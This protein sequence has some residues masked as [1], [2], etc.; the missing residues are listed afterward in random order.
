MYLHLLHCKVSP[1]TLPYPLLKV[2]Y[3]GN[4]SARN[5]PCNRNVLSKSY[6]RSPFV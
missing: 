6:M 2:K 1:E 3:D 4:L 5:R